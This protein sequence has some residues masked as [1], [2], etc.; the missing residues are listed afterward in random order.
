LPT[1]PAHR[2]EPACKPQ[3]SSYHIALLFNANKIY[4]REIIAGIGAYLRSTRVEWDLLVE[5]DFR[6]RMTGIAQ[7]QG[8]GV[9]AD[10]DDP[11]ISEALA[12]ATLPV[13]AVGGS[14]A[15]PS[16]YPEGVPYV[17]TDNFLLVKLAHDHLVEADLQRFALYSL[18]EAAGNRWAQEREKAFARLAPEGRVYRGVQTSAGEWNAAMEQLTEWISSLEKPVGIIAINDAR[19]RHLLHACMVAGIPVPEQVSIVGIDNDPLT[20]SLTRIGLSSVRQ[21]THEMGR[22]AARLLHQMLNG[23]H[24]AG[25]RVVVP[26]AGLNA[27]A[28]SSHTRP[29]SAHVMKARYYIRQYGCQGIKNEQVAEYV[30]V[31][32]STLEHCFRVELGSTVHAALVRHRLDVAQQL[33]RDTDLHAAEVAR[34]AGFTTLQ[35]MYAVF[36]REIGTT[37]AVYRRGTFSA[38]DGDEVK[39]VR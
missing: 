19:A 33:L 26:P 21:G 32:R 13:V 14:Y 35:Y 10:Y 30:G 11:H 15:D 3:R 24:A 6:A 16:D 37:P 9:I 12:G 28:S 23:T 38:G 34:Q 29:F 27:Q 20:Q 22:A 25:K 18:P 39:R 17:A 5:D 2:R 1:Y 8:D 31:S 7:W 36:K 4:D